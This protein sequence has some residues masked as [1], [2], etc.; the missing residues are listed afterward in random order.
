MVG[1]AI[2]RAVNGT[3]N[4][5]ATFLSICLAGA[6]DFDIRRNSSTPA[7]ALEDASGRRS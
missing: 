6:N 4:S 3:G 5:R 7:G 2:A 1:G